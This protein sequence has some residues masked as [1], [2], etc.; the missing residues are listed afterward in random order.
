[1]AWVLLL[2]AGALETC[3]ALCL[4][5]SEGFTRPWPTAGFLVFAIGSFTLLA[6][7]LRDLPVG[8]AYAVWTGIGAAG[9]AIAGIVLFGESAAVL[10]LLS[11]VLI[12]AG[13]V[14]LRVAGAGTSVA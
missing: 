3:F 2:V 1:L 5:A 7:A 13:V 8:T 10:R 12:V 14:G 6:M 9:T 4:K 11:I